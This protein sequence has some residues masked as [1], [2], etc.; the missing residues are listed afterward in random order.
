MVTLVCRTRSPLLF[1]PQVYTL[2]PSWLVVFTS[3]LIS[4]PS[5]LCMKQAVATHRPQ[6]ASSSFCRVYPMGQVGQLILLQDSLYLLTAPA[7]TVHSQCVHTS[8]IILSPAPITVWLRT[9]AFMGAQWQRGQQSCVSQRSS[10]PSGQDGAS[11]AK[12]LTFVA[13]MNTSSLT[14]TH[15]CSTHLS[16]GDCQTSPTFLRLPPII[17]SPRIAPSDSTQLVGVHFPQHSPFDAVYVEPRG[18]LRSHTGG[19]H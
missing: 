18:Q 17:V 1:T 3:R 4:C 5:G 11:I 14:F 2:Q 9:Q 19:V 8:T 15:L 12:Q 6:Q 10:V 7:S 16:S 13:E